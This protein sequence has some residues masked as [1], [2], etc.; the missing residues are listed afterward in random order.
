MLREVD[1]Y[2]RYLR[3]KLEPDPA[4]PR[5]L[6]TVWGQGYRYVPPTRRVD[7]LPHAGDHDRDA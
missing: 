5:Y 6:C 4:H 2:V 7:M 1:V 3:Q